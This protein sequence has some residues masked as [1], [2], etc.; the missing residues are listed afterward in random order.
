MVF[1]RPTQVLGH[2]PLTR[3]LWFPN[4]DSPLC[5]LDSLIEQRYPS[6]L[7]PLCHFYT[8]FTR[9]LNPDEI[10]SPVRQH[11]TRYIHRFNELREKDREIEKSS[12]YRAKI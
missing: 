9:D 11:L 2:Q 5:P 3:C 10:P 12:R 8:K 1:S 4:C 7:T 6:V